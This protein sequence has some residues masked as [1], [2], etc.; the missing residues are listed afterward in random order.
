M[1]NP[2]CL[3][4]ERVEA[5]ARVALDLTHNRVSNLDFYVSLKVAGGILSA[6][7]GLLIMFSKWIAVTCDAGSKAIKLRADI[8]ALRQAS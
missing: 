8:L 1:G 3:L 7:L 2:I 6:I 5:W 4:N